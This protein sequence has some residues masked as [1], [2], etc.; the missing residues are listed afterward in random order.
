[1]RAISSSPRRPRG[2]S[3]R[4]RPWRGSPAEG[5]EVTL[6]F[7]GLDEAIVM[8]VDESTPSSR[9]R[10][11]C[12]RNDGHPESEGTSIAFELA[13]HEAQGC[14]LRFR[15]EGLIP[16]L[17]CYLVCESGW[18]HL[19]ARIASYAETGQGSPYG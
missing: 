17:D 14:L 19:L 13:D 7:E 10:W 15:H 16:L 6:A 1:M 3:R 18:D 5:G 9:V 11:T 2:C 8:R 4:S 12:L